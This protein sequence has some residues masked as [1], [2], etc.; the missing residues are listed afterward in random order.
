MALYFP[1]LNQFRFH[2]GSFYSVSEKNMDNQGPDTK[3]L[4]GVT[5]H[6]FYQPVLR[7][8]PAPVGD[9]NEIDFVIHSSQATW[10]L[11]KLDCILYKVLSFDKY[12]EIDEIGDLGANEADWYLPSRYELEPAYN[13][14]H[15]RGIGGFTSDHYWTSS[16]HNTTNAVYVN[17]DT[18]VS[19]ADLKSA[20]KKVRPIRSFAAAWGTYELGDIGPAGGYI[21][22]HDGTN[23]YEVYWTDLNSV[24]WSN[25]DNALISTTLTTLGEGVNNTNEIMA[26]GG[27]T[28]SAAKNCYDLSSTGDTATATAELL[29]PADFYT[30]ASGRHVYR[31]TKSLSAYV[32]GYYFIR[33]VG[34]SANAYPGA[35]FYESNVFEI[36]N[37]IEGSY[38]FVATN[39]ENDFGNIWINATPTTWYLKL[40]V[41]FNMY[42]PKTKIKKEVYATDSGALTTL[43]STINRVY[44]LETMPIPLWFAELIQMATGL[45]TIY[46][47]DLA[48]NFEDTPEIE[49]IQQSNLCILRGDCV[50]T[51][52]NDYYLLNL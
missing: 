51:G 12:G 5:P 50:L 7:T 21:V 4:E 34:D 9:T 24:A 35:I 43:R 47:N 28:A 52:F 18:G 38:A 11:E 15:A 44:E 2:H 49:P 8:W 10:V 29:T 30:Y 13:V 25:I 40:V 19:S 45:S 36:S 33:L 26:Q 37:S 20:S 48:A 23:Y 27:H 46:V 22:A 39:F 32:N 42:I 16:E 3:Y 31:F 1:K 14:L 6:R 17:F 41:P